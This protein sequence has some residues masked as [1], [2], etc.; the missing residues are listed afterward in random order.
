M[1][2]SR[3]KKSSAPTRGGLRAGMLVGVPLLLSLGGLAGC[4]PRLIQDYAVRDAELVFV[5]QEGTSYT[6]GDCQ[7]AADGTLTNC[8]L[9]EVEFE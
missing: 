7:R 4:A 2:F 6:L 3:T 9:R 5:V 8:Q 1:R